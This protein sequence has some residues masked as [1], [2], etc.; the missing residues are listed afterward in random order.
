MGQSVARSLDRESP[1]DALALGVAV[2]L[3][4][5]QLAAKE[6]EV[7]DTPLE[8]LPSQHGKLTFSHVEPTAVLGREMQFQSPGKRQR[9]LG[10]KRFIERADLVSVEIVHDQPDPRR[11]GVVGL[12]QFTNLPCPKEEVT[13]RY[14]GR[15]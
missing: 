7:C 2:A 6:R 15:F 14:N 3:P 11:F 8:A 12:E 4:G 13:L 10:R 1:V 5:G 9:L